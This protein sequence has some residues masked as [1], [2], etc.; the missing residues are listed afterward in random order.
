MLRMRL[1]ERWNEYSRAALPA[2]CGQ[3]QHD[4]MKKSFYAGAVSL[5][6]ILMS[7][8]VTEVPDAESIKVIAE[9]EA[10][11]RH[12]IDTERKKKHGTG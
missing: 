11:F 2:N 6:C 12:H 5:H 4:D 9:I 10:E 8:E 1:L 3:A 7:D